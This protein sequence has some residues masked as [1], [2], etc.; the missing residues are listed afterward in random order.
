MATITL[1]LDDRVK[2][3]LETVARGRG[4]TLSDLIRT[5]LDQL[6]APAERE[7]QQQTAHAPA[8][9]TM[10]ERQ[11]LALLH[12]ILARVIGDDGDTDGDRDYQL[13]RAEVLESGFVQ[14]Y[15]TEFIGIE[16]E[17]SARAC[18]FVM[19]TLDMF[20]RITFS[21]RK[22]EAEGVELPAELADDLVFSG[23]DLNDSREG[24]LLD[25][26]RHL[27]DKDHWAELMPVFGPENDRGNS[28]SPRAA[29]YARMLEEL[30]TMPVDGLSLRGGQDSYFLGIEELQRLTEA[31][32][33]P[34]RRPSA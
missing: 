12:R 4:Q 22:L 10:V 17:L 19:N 23:F 8:S 18:E 32:V 13:K 7:G 28:H 16:P 11:Q 20:R 29:V 3:Q 31:R 15:A 21:V 24:Q 6:L 26:A 14:Q 2:D 34:S 27:V 9:L 33:H 25:Y 5:T 30:Q 1:R